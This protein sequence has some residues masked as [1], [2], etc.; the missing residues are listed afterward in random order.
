MWFKRVPKLGSY[1]AVPLIYQA[2]LTDDALEAAVADYLAVSQQKAELQKEIDV[3]DEEQNVKK[4][5][6]QSNNEPCEAETR[7]W[8]L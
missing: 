2:C 1:M 8:P 3:F 4:E 5:A 6:A 7:D